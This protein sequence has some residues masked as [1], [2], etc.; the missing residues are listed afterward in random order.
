MSLITIRKLDPEVKER[1]QSLARCNGRSM[2]GEIRSLLRLAVG[3]G[4]TGVEQLGTEER[5]KQMQ[6]SHVQTMIGALVRRANG[7]DD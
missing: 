6:K 3:L 2:E 4:P 1:I 7:N 5:F